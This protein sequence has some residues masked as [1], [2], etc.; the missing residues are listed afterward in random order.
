[1]SSG[2][3][4]KKDNYDAILENDK[5]FSRVWKKHFLGRWKVYD[6][7]I[8]KQLEKEGFDLHTFYTG[9]EISAAAVRAFGTPD[10]RRDLWIEITALLDANPGIEDIVYRFALTRLSKGVEFV[11]MGTATHKGLKLDFT[12]FSLKTLKKY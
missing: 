11:P 2:C 7:E 9:K 5:M 10:Q 4:N 12:K 1:M 6:A 3:D 8:V